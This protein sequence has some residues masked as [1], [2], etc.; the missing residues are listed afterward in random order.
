MSQY[1]SNGTHGRVCTFQYPHGVPRQQHYASQGP[2]RAEEAAQRERMRR[3][4]NTIG[5]WFGGVTTGGGAL[6]R[7]LGGSEDAVESAAG[8]SSGV[9]MPTPGDPAVLPRRF[10]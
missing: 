4:M 5:L 10:W 1:T 2:T 9:L 8:A 3:Q 6:V 7:L